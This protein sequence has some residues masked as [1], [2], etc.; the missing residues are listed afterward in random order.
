MDANDARELMAFLKRNGANVVLHDQ[1]VTVW[2]N[3]LRR[4]TLNQSI[5]ASVW[6]LER[7]HP[8]EVA[9]A[10]IA[11]AARSLA[12]SARFREPM[13]PDHPEESA[14]FCRCCAGDVL[15]G[16]RPAE[17]RGRPLRELTTTTPHASASRSALHPGHAA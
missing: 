3:A 9:P 2:A 13:C 15:A 11:A 12:A 7:N 16:E 6:F 5:A 17:L 4:F 8:R 1:V 10:T 14:R